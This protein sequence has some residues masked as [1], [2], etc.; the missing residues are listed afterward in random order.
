[1]PASAKASEITVPRQFVLVSTAILPGAKWVNVVGAF[2]R[3]Y[4]FARLLCYPLGFGLRIAGEVDY[5]RVSFL[6][7]G[8]RTHSVEVTVVGGDRSRSIHQCAGGSI[9]GDR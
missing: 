6:C 3:F 2:A 4:Q 8:A 5:Y 7:C 9:I 1:M